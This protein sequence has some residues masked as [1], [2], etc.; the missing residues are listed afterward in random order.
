MFCSKIYKAI[1]KTCYFTVYIYTTCQKLQNSPVLPA[2][3]CN[4]SCSGPINILKWSKG[5]W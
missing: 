4:S 5:K 3:Y 2:V 1:Y